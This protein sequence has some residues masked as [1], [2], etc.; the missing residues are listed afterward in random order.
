MS[1][2]VNTLVDSGLAVVRMVEPVGD[3]PV[4]QAV[5]GLLYLRCQRVT[6][7]QETS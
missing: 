4:W 5:P 1:T 3:R 7:D 6:G 2:Y